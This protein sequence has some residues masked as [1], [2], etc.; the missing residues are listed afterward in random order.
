MYVNHKEDQHD[1][2]VGR[3][4]RNAGTGGDSSNSTANANQQSGNNNKE[5]QL[6]SKLKE[7]LCTNLCMSAADAEKLI[8]QASEN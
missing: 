6:Q 2:V 5:L 1:R 8:G 4:K 3:F 7:V